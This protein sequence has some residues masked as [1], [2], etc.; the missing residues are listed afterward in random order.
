V[1]DPLTEKD[2]QEVFQKCRRW[3]DRDSF[4]SDGEFYDFYSIS[5]EYFGY[6]HVYCSLHIIMAQLKFRHGMRN[7]WT[8]TRY[9]LKQPSNASSSME[10]ETIQH[11]NKLFQRITL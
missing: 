11:F 6:H 4:K 8:L 7:Y 2:F 3:W 10:K 9:F 1:F 5:P